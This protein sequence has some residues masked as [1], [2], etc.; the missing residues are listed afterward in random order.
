MKRRTAVIALLVVSLLSFAAWFGTRIGFDAG[1]RAGTV[2]GA[3][4]AKG[5]ELV[6]PDVLQMPETDRLV[7]GHLAIRCRLEDEPPVAE[8]VV[9]CLRSAA[10]GNDLSKERA[11]LVRLLPQQYALSGEKL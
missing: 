4:A 6:W 1:L 8:N 9:R 7:L 3:Q 5:L 2:A 11:T 10:A